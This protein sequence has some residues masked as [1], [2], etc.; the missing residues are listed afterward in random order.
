MAWGS[1]TSVL[2]GIDAGTLQTQLTAMQAALLKLQAGASVATVA[3]SQGDGSRS[4]SYV[5]SSIDKLTQA[6]LGVQRQLDLLNGI[7]INRRRPILPLF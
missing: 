6:I 4:V 7:N 5:V 3:Y 1:R 2:D